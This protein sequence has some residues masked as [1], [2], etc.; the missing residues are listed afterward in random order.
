MESLL[1][2]ADNLEPWLRR[3]NKQHHRKTKNLTIFDQIIFR[4]KLEA[5]YSVK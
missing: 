2:K 3:T 1:T 4:F 5:L